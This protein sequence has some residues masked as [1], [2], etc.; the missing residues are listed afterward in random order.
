MKFAAASIIIT[1]LVS[2]T[3]ASGSTYLRAASKVPSK[4]VSKHSSVNTKEQLVRVQDGHHD[5]VE[6]SAGRNPRYGT[7]VPAQLKK[8]EAQHTNSRIGINIVG[9]EESDVGEFP[10]FGTLIPHQTLSLSARNE[11]SLTYQLELLKI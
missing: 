5:I 1:S 10:Y 7:R 11:I 9:G 3:D 6:D 4:I 8:K 2:Y